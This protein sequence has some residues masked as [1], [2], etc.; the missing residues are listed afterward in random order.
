MILQRVANQLRLRIASCALALVAALC[1]EMAQ[2]AYFPTIVYDS[3]TTIGPG[4][5]Y[6][7]ASNAS[8]KWQIRIL[9]V[10][11]TDKNIELTPVKSQN[12]PALETVSSMAN[13]VHAI[14]AV[15][16]GYFDTGGT[17]GSYSVLKIDGVTVTNNVASR[18][19]RSTFG[20]WDN[21]NS[22]VVGARINSSGVPSPLAEPDWSGVVDAIGGGPNLVT[23]GTV[24]VNENDEQ[25]T[26]GSGSGINSDTA[27][28]RT[29]VGWISATRRV[30]FV[31]VD[32][33]QPAWSTG[34]TCVD[35]AKLM[36]DLGCDRAINYDGGGS[37][38]MWVN[39]AVVNQP[40]DGSE[41][42]NAMCWA[43][44]PSNYVDNTNAE[45]SVTGTWSASANAGYYNTNSLIHLGGGG[46]SAAT[47]RPDLLAAKYEVYAWWVAAGNR[48]TVAPYTVHHITGDTL[49]TMNQQLNGSQW[50]LLGTFDFN[51]GTSG[52]VRLTDSVSGTEYVSAD[53]VKFVK[54]GGFG[55]P[56][57]V[58]TWVDYQ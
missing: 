49:I 43:V 35:L 52:Y 57:R 4:T 58:A 30:F 14:A 21:H 11:L 31:T 45:F 18:P 19:P 8:P 48:S 53:A 15:N 47:W 25:T 29:A 39:G 9:E 1:C 51:T 13:R 50:N 33:R 56:A 23:T 38:E 46:G 27:Q 54:V 22:K 12:Y 44:I 26:S 10:D 3:S 55:T 20:I 7:T 6:R 2:A 36:I 37:T 24:D 34:M 5:I 28:P 40:S 41:R 17:G 42:P 32:G 16:A